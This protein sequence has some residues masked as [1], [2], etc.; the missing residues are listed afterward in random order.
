MSTIPKRSRRVL[1]RVAAAGVLVSVPA[2]IVVAPALADPLPQSSPVE[3]N[4]QQD[5]G[6]GQ[7]NHHGEHRRHDEH[8]RQWQDR[9]E[10][11]NQ[12]QQG[13]GGQNQGLFGGG[14]P[15]GSLGGLG[16]FGS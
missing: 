5:Q 12:W 9:P 4:W 7:D 15:L 11:Y 14:N 10:Q 8:D 16:G 13:Q 1:M 6:Q 3:H 2:I